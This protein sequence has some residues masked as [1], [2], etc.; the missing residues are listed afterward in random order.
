MYC[1]CF[2]RRVWRSSNPRFLHINQS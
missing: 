2:Y 1:S